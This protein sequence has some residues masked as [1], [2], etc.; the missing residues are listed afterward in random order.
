MSRRSP[1]QSVQTGSSVKSRIDVQEQKEQIVDIG[2]TLVDLSA[3][4]VVT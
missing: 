3:G 4:A 1:C 2:Y